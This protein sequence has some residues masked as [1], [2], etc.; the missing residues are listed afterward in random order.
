MLDLFDAV[1]P[2]FAVDRLIVGV[3]DAV[4][5]DQ[6]QLAAVMVN[7]SHVAVG[8]GMGNRKLH[9]FVKRITLCDVA[10]F[11]P[12]PLVD[13]L[14]QTLVKFPV[15]GQGL[16]GKNRVVLAMLFDDE[17]DKREIPAQVSDVGYGGL[18]FPGQKL[19]IF[20]FC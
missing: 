9:H 12:L 20:R 5:F 3:A 4:A 14:R 2:R 19:L 15:F 6:L 10:I 1:R 7:D 11:P 13:F 16:K 8:Y 17:I 18:P